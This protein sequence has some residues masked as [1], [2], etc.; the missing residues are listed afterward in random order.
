MSNIPIKPT[1]TI[2]PTPSKPKV[3][4]VSVQKNLVNKQTTKNSDD[5]KN[6]KKKLLILLL[7]L[8]LLA[9]AG[10]SVLVYFLV[11]PDDNINLQLTITTKI[12]GEI[13]GPGTAMP[14]QKFIPG[15]EIPIELNFKIY[16][17]SVLSN[18]NAKVYAR[19]K[20][21]AYVDET[22]VSGLFDPQPVQ[23]DTLDVI[24]GDDNYFYYK[25]V[26]TSENKD[27]VAFRA[28]DFVAEYENNILN[29]KTVSIQIE[30][31]ILEANVYAIRDVWNTAPNEWRELDEIAKA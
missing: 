17:P 18:S 21:S 7:L 8:I 23:G 24:K 4:P 22:Y 16:D 20:I 13:T 29:G 19:Y 2:N 12:N 26:F 1:N 3:A 11:K 30:L 10:V 27:I 9:V 5:K 6:N 28:L 14:T 31:E 25:Y 15:D